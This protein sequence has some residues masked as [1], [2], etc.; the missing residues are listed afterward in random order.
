MSEKRWVAFSRAVALALVAGLFLLGPI[1]SAVAQ[2]WNLGSKRF[3]TNAAVAAAPLRIVSTGYSDLSTFRFVG[4]VGGVSFI[5]VAQPDHTATGKSIDLA[6]DPALPDGSRLVVRVD[7]KALRTSIPDWQLRPIVEFAA[8]EFN[9]V[10]SLFGEGPEGENYYY[11][12]Y[13]D[14]MKD[15]LMGMRLLH[16]DILFIALDEHWR[17]PRYGGKVVLGAGGAGSERGAVDESQGEAAGGVARSEMA[18]V[19]SN[20]RRY[21]AHIRRRQR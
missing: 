2:E 8:S 10:V 1:A 21:S 19:G 18:F 14:A 11:I 5:A 16:A 17:L 20:G 3:L 4:R 6:Y 9:A 7:S 15:T 13:H 12:Q